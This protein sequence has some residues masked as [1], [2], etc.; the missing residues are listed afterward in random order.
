MDRSQKRKMKNMVKDLNYVNYETLYI[1]AKL[2]AITSSYK[3]NC[4]GHEKSKAAI[5]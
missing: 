4:S 5:S 2:M 1:P 3:K